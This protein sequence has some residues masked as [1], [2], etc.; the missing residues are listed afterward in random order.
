MRNS[1]LAK[2]YHCEAKDGKQISIFDKYPNSAGYKRRGTSRDAAKRIGNCKATHD[3]ILALL[4]QQPMTA[5]E[6]AEALKRPVLYVRPRLSELV[7]KGLICETGRRRL[8]ES[9]L[10]AAEWMVQP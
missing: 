8:N 7:A 3:K 1:P 2:K 10:S 9:G 5:D 4:R 6:V